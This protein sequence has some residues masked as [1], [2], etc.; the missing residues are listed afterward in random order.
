MMSPFHNLFLGKYAVSFLNSGKDSPLS[1]QLYRVTSSSLKSPYM[2]SS[3]TISMYFI[4]NHID[5]HFRYRLKS[6]NLR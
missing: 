2:N 5:Y 3:V 6:K 4:S 1:G